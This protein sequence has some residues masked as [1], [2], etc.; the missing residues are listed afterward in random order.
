[1]HSGDKK[2]V[3]NFWLQSLEGRDHGTHGRRL[4]DNIKMDLREIVL[5]SSGT[6]RDWWRALV[7]R[8]MHFRVP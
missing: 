4:K 2:C 6:D 1:M 7:D 5:D 8:L 3:H